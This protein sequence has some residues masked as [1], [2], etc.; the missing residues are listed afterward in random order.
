MTRQMLDK[1]P[2]ERRIIAEVPPLGVE[3]VS[4]QQNFLP[5]EC[6]SRLDVS[7]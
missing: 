3:R 6:P 5:G 2:I 4:V 1:S 7:A